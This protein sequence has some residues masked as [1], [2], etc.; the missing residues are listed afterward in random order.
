L[1]RPIERSG[2]FLGVSLSTIAAAA[3]AAVQQQN[4][5][6][7]Q[8]DKALHQWFTVWQKCEITLSLN[9]S[10]ECY[11]EPVASTRLAVTLKQ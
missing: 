4:H 5:M 8:L 2:D 7:F 9:V 6:E 3:A 1:H 11:R 10:P